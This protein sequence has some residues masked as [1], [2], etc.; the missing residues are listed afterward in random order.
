M[1]LPYVLL[2]LPML[3]A[4]QTGSQ[5]TK[6]L[7]RETRRDDGPGDVLDL[8]GESFLDVIDTLLPASASND[9]P[10]GTPITVKIYG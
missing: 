5:A 8:I 2:L 3:V 7:T 6:T 4:A 1:L 10:E 9:N